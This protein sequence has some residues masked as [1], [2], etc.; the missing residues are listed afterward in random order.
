VEPVEDKGLASKW[1]DP[2]KKLEGAASA[3]AIELGLRNQIFLAKGWTLRGKLFLGD[4]N[5]LI[6]VIPLP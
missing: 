2:Q 4:D 3:S 6:A 5:A 1:G